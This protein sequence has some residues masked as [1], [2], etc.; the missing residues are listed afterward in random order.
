MTQEWILWLLVGLLTVAT[1]GLALAL[2]RVRSRA[3][4]FVRASDTSRHDAAELRGRVADLERRLQPPTATEEPG[5]VITDLPEPGTRPDR[6]PAESAVPTRIEGRLFADLVLRETVVRTAGLAAG[7]RRALTPEN[8]FRMRYEMSR[9][10]KRS[11][12]LRRQELRA[13]RR[14]LQE[15]EQATRAAEDAA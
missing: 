7:V 3:A 1:A 15:R 12:K 4:E 8:R 6:S 13:A 2:I 14:Y 10:T 11:R 5:F 9:A